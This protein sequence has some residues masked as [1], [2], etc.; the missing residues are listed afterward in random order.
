[1]GLRGPRRLP[2]VSPFTVIFG[3]ES[4]GDSKPAGLSSGAVDTRLHPGSSGDHTDQPR[5]PTFILLP[6]TQALGPLAGLFTRPLGCL[7]G[8]L[9]GFLFGLLAPFLFFLAALLLLFT[10]A[11]V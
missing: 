6:L 11:L 5:L 1:M 10:G 4:F 2:L 7:F 3:A 9:F 8:L